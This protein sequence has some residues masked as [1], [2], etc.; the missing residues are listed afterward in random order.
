MFEILY[1][2]VLPV[3]FPKKLDEPVKMTFYP[4]EKASYI[5]G[6]N[7]STFIRESKNKFK[8]HV[9]LRV[10]G[11]GIAYFTNIDDPA[12]DHDVV[13]KISMRLK[14]GSDEW[15]ELICKEKDNWIAIVRLKATANGIKNPC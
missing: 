6:A 13:E 12:I 8:A 4:Y 10:D 3:I 11:N 1:E 15:V 5:L 2:R 7:A 14:F 9:A